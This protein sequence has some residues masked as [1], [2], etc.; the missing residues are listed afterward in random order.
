MCILGVSPLLPFEPEPAT[1]APY[2]RG[3]QP[4]LF[5]GWKSPGRGGGGRP[6]RQD[7]GERRAALGP[8]HGQ[9]DC[10][11]QHAGRP[12][13]L[14][15]LPGILA[16]RDSGHRERRR[17]PHLGNG[18]K[19][20]GA[21]LHLSTAARLSCAHGRQRFS[22]RRRT[23]EPSPSLR[24]TANLSLSLRRRRSDSHTT[25]NLRSSQRHQRTGRRRGTAEFLGRDE[26][27]TT[28]PLIWPCR[29]RDAVRGAL[30]DP[31]DVFGAARVYLL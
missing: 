25:G 16:K 1:D 20:A 12:H 17:R 11:P 10:R 22:F 7:H 9:A 24:R 28:T 18:E 31:E 6:N 26:E 5:A 15:P 19:V 13:A 14:A 8:R 3:P 2:L 29:S 23:T 21:A 4:G 27:L 30:A